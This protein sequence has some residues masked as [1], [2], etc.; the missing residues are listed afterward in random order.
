METAQPSTVA[1]D[2]TENDAAH[3]RHA[4]ALSWE[5][6]ENGRHPFGALVVSGA[7][8]V[9]VRTLN[10]FSGDEGGPTQHAELVAVREAARLLPAT[11]LREATLYTSAEPC[12]MCAGATYWCGIGRVVY[13]LGEDQLL[14]I[15]GDHPENPTLQ[16]PCRVVF[17]AGQRPTEVVGPVLDD[18]A[19]AAHEGFWERPA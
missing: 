3:L 17:A 13:A 4:I 7:G 18:E 8:D 14:Q 16:L 5:A 11:E 15:T 19:A 9:V 2:L 12:A 10:N 1:A 6:R